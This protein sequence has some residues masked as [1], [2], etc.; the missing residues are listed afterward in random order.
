MMDAMI[1]TCCTIIDAALT[2]HQLSSLDT[3]RLA[4]YWKTWTHYASTFNLIL[5]AFY[6]ALRKICLVDRMTRIESSVV[7]VTAYGV[8]P[9]TLWDLHYVTLRRLRQRVH[10]NAVI[11]HVVLFL[12][13]DSRESTSLGWTQQHYGLMRLNDVLLGMSRMIER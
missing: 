3:P 8:G 9:S 10:V 12:A 4:A 1:I 5:T 7:S 13:G 6:W 2:V 11:V